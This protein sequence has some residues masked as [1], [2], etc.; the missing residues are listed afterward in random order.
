MRG[1]GG[2]VLVTLSRSP[3][4]AISHLGKIMIY[5]YGADH[6]DHPDHLDYHPYDV[7]SP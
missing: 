2:V 7:G 1:G 4:E 3:L 6:L 5:L